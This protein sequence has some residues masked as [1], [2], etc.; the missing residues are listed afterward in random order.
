MRNLLLIIP[1]VAIIF[2]AGCSQSGITGQAVR[3]QEQETTSIEQATS[4]ET[5]TSIFFAFEENQK[6]CKNGVWRNQYLENGTVKQICVRNLNQFF[7][8]DI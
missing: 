6:T 4:V 2:I 3:D 8:C 7:A 1:L 5:T